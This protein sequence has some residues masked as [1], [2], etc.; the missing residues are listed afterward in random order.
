MEPEKDPR[1]LDEAK[2]GMMDAPP[3][4][5][6]PLGPPSEGAPEVEGLATV[7]PPLGTVTVMVY[8]DVVGGKF[9]VWYGTPVGSLFP[10]LPLPGPPLPGLG[11][12][13]PPAGIVL[14]MVKRGLVVGL[15]PKLGLPELSPAPPFPGPFGPETVV[16]MYG[17]PVSLGEPPL[18]G[19]L[20]PG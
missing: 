13:E 19:A 8:G 5:L 2:V 18:P 14:V 3:W 1:G 10:G 7:L 15:V 11:L 4:P 9:P 17:E 6:G 20:I 12:P 16:M